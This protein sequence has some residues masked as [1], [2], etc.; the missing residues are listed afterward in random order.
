MTFHNFAMIFVG[1]LGELQTDYTT[2]CD[3]LQET[4]MVLVD[5][6]RTGVSEAPDL[7]GPRQNSPPRPAP[8]G[9]A[10]HERTPALPRSPDGAPDIRVPVS[11]RFRGPAFSGPAHSPPIPRSGAPLFP[12]P[13]S[14]SPPANGLGISIS[15]PGRCTAMGPR[16]FLQCPASRLHLPDPRF[17]LAHC[18]PRCT[19]RGPTFS[20]KK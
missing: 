3:T 12:G 8:R 5:S 13:R 2:K 16:L 11:C 15:G 4:M 10:G 7:P 6:V 20:G 19:A 18:L 1:F 9:G 14:G 17:V